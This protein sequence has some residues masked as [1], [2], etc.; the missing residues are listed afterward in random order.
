V[1]WAEE[2]LVTKKNGSVGGV[3]GIAMPFTPPT[4]KS[5]T[6]GA[7]VGMATKEIDRE[8]TARTAVGCGRVG[9]TALEVDGDKIPARAKGTLGG[10]G[11]RYQMKNIRSVLATM[12]SYRREGEGGDIGRGLGP[13]GTRAVPGRLASAGRSEQRKGGV[14]VSLEE[15]AKELRSSAMEGKGLLAICGTGWSGVEKSKGAG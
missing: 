10:G 9:E 7:I 3:R 14:R 15:A 5:I 2:N 6:R 1:I 12:E 11:R 13:K 8:G 4:S